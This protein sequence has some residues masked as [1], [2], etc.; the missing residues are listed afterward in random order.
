M[1]PSLPD[2]PLFAGTEPDLPAGVPVYVCELFESTA[3]HVAAL[4]LTRYS[5]RAIAHRIRWHNHIDRGNREFVFNN[6]W[7]P[8]LARWFMAR[9]PELPAFFELRESPGD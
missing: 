6:N 2:L 9:H 4:G 5:A 1:T 3:L 7:T 8:P